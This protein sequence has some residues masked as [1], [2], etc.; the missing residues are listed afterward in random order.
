MLSHYSAFCSP[1]VGLYVILGWFKIVHRAAV[2]RRD[3][4]LGNRPGRRRRIGGGVYLRPTLQHWS[5]Y[6]RRATVQRFGDFY[7]SDW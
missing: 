3:C 7:L 2:R 1:P 5:V 6:P 4:V